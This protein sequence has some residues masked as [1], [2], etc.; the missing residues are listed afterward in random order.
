MS[1]IFYMPSFLTTNDF[2]QHIIAVLSSQI[3]YFSTGDYMTTY[4]LIKLLSSYLTTWCENLITRRDEVPCTNIRNM[5]QN[6]RL[7]HPP[8]IWSSTVIQLRTKTR[9]SKLSITLLNIV[10][11][12]KKQSSH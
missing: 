11:P 1:V 8:A 5:T 7:L 4:T 6:P 3:H 9:D 2:L 12:S 10:S